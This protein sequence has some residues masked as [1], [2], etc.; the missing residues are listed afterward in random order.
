MTSQRSEVRNP[1]DSVNSANFIAWEGAPSDGVF[2]RRN[3]FSTFR[4]EAQGSPEAVPTYLHYRACED[5]VDSLT[6]DIKHFSLVSPS[7]KS[8]QR[9][10]QYHTCRSQNDQKELAELFILKFANLDDYLVLL[11]RSVWIGLTRSHQ[12]RIEGAGVVSLASGT[13]PSLSPFTVHERNFSDAIDSWMDAATLSRTYKNPTTGV[14]LIG[15]HPKLT[16]PPPIVPA[17]SEE[18]NAASHRAINFLRQEILNSGV[19]GVD[20]Y[21]NPL[22]PLFADFYLRVLST[23]SKETLLLLIEHKL[24]QT[25]RTRDGVRFVLYTDDPRR[26]PM[27]PLRQWH[28]LIF[29]PE[30]KRSYW[31]CFGRHEVK[32]DWTAKGSLSLSDPEA[33]RY[34]YQDVIE[35]I[36]HMQDK[37]SEAILAVQGVQMKSEGSEADLKA[38]VTS[39]AAANIT[40]A[41]TNPAMVA[42]YHREWH[43]RLHWLYDRFNNQCKTRSSLVLLPL[44][45]RHP[46]GN[47]VIAEYTWTKPQQRDFDQTRALPIQAFD[48]FT[49]EGQFQKPRR[50]VVMRFWDL[51]RHRSSSSFTYGDFISMRA[52]YRYHPSTDQPY[53]IVGSIVD[54]DILANS[55]LQPEYLLLPSEFQNQRGKPGEKREHSGDQY[56]QYRS[57]GEGERVRSL[58]KGS[59]D[60]VNKDI[61]P[62]H[63]LVDFDSI[64]THILDLMS[65]NEESEIWIKNPQTATSNLTPPVSKKKYWTTLPEVHQAAWDFGCT[66]KSYI[67]C[68][69]LI[70]CSG[71]KI[72]S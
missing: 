66:W 31:F 16:S 14:E 57:T 56:Y 10:Y 21:L 27:H 23:T 20:F 35:M 49:G 11:P 8:Q 54:P 40:D 39:N 63:F 72:Q 34:R 65:E 15:Y 50:C 64:H 12:T 13:L 32:S 33:K 9:D 62:L 48:A 4:K 7:A 29:Q 43:S 61:D 52:P 38:L 45:G 71:T 46:Y 37:A 24:G 30:E 53:M 3:V 2:V 36:K 59:E 47:Y 55:T 51:F 68:V 6:F 67:L 17:S 26:S 5:R 28:W 60:M 18:P 19:I 22:A 25:F 41:Q 70:S 69:K 42:K 58:E 44:D 1:L